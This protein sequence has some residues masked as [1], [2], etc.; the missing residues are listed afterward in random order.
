MAYIAQKKAMEKGNAHGKRQGDRIFS[1][2]VCMALHFLPCI[3]YAALWLRSPR[4]ILDVGSPF[5]KQ[6]FRNRAYIVHHRGVLRLVVPLSSPRYGMAMKDIRVEGGQRW[7]RILWRSI[8]SAYGKAPYFLYYA[9]EYHRW[10]HGSQRFLC[11]L[12]EEGL[13]L[14][15]GHLGVP[16]SY[17]ISEQ[18][19][20]NGIVG[21]TDARRFFVDRRKK[22]GEEAIYSPY[23]YRHTFS[24]PFE[25]NVSA[26]DV[27]FNHQEDARDILWRSFCLWEENKVRGANG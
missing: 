26:I 23:R 15:W 21:G 5:E 7:R 10:L 19:Q 17:R 6:T 9:E 25:R 8:Q 14:L 12:N 27:L 16:L 13:R 24:V 1:S 2:S 18:A 20:E 11:D 22:G 4:V 3:A